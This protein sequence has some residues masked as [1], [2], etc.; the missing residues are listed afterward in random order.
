MAK[1]DLAKRIKKTQ[2]S[3]EFIVKMWSLQLAL[4]VWISILNDSDVMGKDV[5]GAKRLK[6]LGEEFNKRIAIFA[7]AI[8]N[9][10]E[11]DY[12]REKIDQMQVQI[13]GDKAE[14]WNERYIGWE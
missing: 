4:D 11:A 6:K 9:D 3:R 7:K 14:P 1:N 13:F 2:E 10:V 8:T 5:F 12:W